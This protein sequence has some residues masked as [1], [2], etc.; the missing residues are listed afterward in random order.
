MVEVDVVITVATLMLALGLFVTDVLRAEVVA[1]LV[2]V[3]LMVTGVVTPAEGV[4]GFSNPATMTILALF[5]M[6]AGI[7]RTG[8][9]TLAAKRLAR[10]TGKS[11]FRMLVTIAVVVIPAS[12]FINNTAAVAILIPLVLTLA[13]EAGRSASKVLI[14]LSYMSMLAGT[15]TLI[16]TST[17]VLTSAL[18]HQYAGRPFGMFEFSKV[19]LTVVAVGMAYLFLVGRFLIPARAKGE[20]LL[21][22]YHIKD[23]LAEVRI[24]AGSPLIGHP[25]NDTDL[26]SRFDVDVIRILRG[27]EAI[28]QPLVGIPLHEA[29]ILVIR[30]SKESLVG[31]RAAE[32]VDPLPEVEDEVHLTG[33]DVRIVEVILAPNSGIVGTTLKE[34]KFRQRYNASVL[35]IKKRE[36]LFLRRLHTTRLEFGDTLLVATTREALDRLREDRG[37]IFGEEEPAERYRT[38]QI[39]LALVILAGVVALA[40]LGIY[41]IMVAA[42]AGAVVMALAG[43]LRGKELWTSIRWDVIFLLAGLIPL[44]IAIE[45]TGVAAFI[46]GHLAAFSMGLPDLGVIMVF[47]FASMALTEMISNSA[48][49]VLLIPVAFASAATLGVDPTPLVLAVMFAASA[50]FMTP[51]GYQTNLMVYGPGEYKFTD[52]TRVGAP[53]NLILLFTTSYAISVWFPLR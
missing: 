2:M 37:F 13:R 9:V 15:V 7:Y 14:P 20:A 45:K 4:S 40:A 18:Y 6:S 42:M 1:L 43:I 10:A 11:E 27:D 24:L 32:G 34:S 21:E 16:G 39:P 5:I 53:L 22:R 52:F 29:D 26:K 25:V 28:E 44:G 19:G 3:I 17:N 36:R 49:V 30:A 47:Y 46:G 35:A 12:A 23:Y 50:S 51:I 31:I 33:P 48:T 41:P 38:R 8:I